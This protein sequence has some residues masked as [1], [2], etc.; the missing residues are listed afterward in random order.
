MFSHMT[1]MHDAV[2]DTHIAR[3]DETGDE[4]MRKEGPRWKH[5]GKTANG[6]VE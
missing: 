6:S 3:A 4:K 5:V 2:N 1:V